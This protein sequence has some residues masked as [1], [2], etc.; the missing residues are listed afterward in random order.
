MNFGLESNA[1]LY[2]WYYSASS[3]LAWLPI[4]FLY[5]SEYLSLSDILLL[6][7][8]YYVIVVLLEVPSGY[9]SDVLGRKKT[10]I[11]GAIFLCIAIILYIMGES[12]YPLV[13]GQVFFAGHMSFVSGTNTVFHYESL[14]SQNR[15]SEYGSREALVNKWALF[16]GG[17]AA[18]IGGWLAGFS[19]EYAYW[20]SLM[21]AIVALVITF[22]FEEPGHDK[23]ERPSRDFFRQ[24][25][26]SLSFLKRVNIGWVFA[27]YVLMFLMV[28]VPY[29][30]YQPYLYLLE[31]GQMLNFSSA[32]VMSGLLYAAAMFVS[33]YA[34][35]QSITWKNK[36]GLKK[37]LLLMLLVMF[38]VVG[39]MSLILHPALIIV[40]LFR[41]FAWSAVKPPVNELITPNIDS[42]HRATF[43]SMM[44]LASRL[45]FFILLFVLSLII[46]A[47]EVSDWNSIS[48]IL[49]IC[50]GLGLVISLPI[51][52]TM[53]RVDFNAK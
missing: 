34:A 23:E 10:L 11:L 52:V 1:K 3:F 15:E 9:F 6:E 39:S 22:L 33:A 5:F 28:H 4:F 32:P 18:L 47:D 16:S 12:F 45:S 26:V 35:G 31:K 21:G 29:E 42:G 30:F 27:F 37:Y 8:I 14:K 13:L 2:S 50:F 48:R 17:I 51:L 49:K 38:I 41:S 36:I 20:L 40:I 46:S 44:S 53:K 24:I 19:L 25:I 43:H 7:S